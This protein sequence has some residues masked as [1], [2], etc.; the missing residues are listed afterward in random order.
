MVALVRVSVCS[1]GPLQRKIFTL[2]NLNNYE[3]KNPEL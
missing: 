2:V 3:K 1:A